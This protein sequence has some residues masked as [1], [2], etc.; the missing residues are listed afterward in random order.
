MRVRRK[1]PSRTAVFRR[2]A[3]QTAGAGDPSV[4]ETWP[5]CPHNFKAAATVRCVAN[6]LA[7]FS[8]M[9]A[10][11]RK[12]YVRSYKAAYCSFQTCLSIMQPLIGHC[13]R[14]RAALARG[15]L[16]AGCA[17]PRVCW[18]GRVVGHRLT[19]EPEISRTKK[20]FLTFR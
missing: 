1:A 10:S 7:N 3:T 9:P 15:W 4:D 14:L 20:P 18:T 8:L 6:S 12:R 11:Y 19:S 13:L 2:E 5:C 16:M 17:T